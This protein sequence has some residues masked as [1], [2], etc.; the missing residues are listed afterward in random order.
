ME[1]QLWEIGVLLLCIGLLILFLSLSFTVLTVNS[2]IKKVENL[3]DENVTEIGDLI[4]NAAGISGSV[5][6]LISSG[7]KMI[8]LISGLGFISSMTK[9]KN[10]RRD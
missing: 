8:G 6:G 9:S 1:I 5:N 7:S 10:S 2:T 3:V 4:R